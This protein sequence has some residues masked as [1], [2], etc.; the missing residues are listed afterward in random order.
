VDLPEDR[1]RE[2]RQD[3]LRLLTVQPESWLHLL[4]KLINEEQAHCQHKLAYEGATCD[5]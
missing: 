3:R 1:L 2:L 5:D 4:T